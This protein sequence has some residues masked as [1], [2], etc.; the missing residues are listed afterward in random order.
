MQVFCETVNNQSEMMFKEA[1]RL[2]RILLDGVV[3]RLECSGRQADW[4]L[5]HQNFIGPTHNDYSQMQL[6]FSGAHGVSFQR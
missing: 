6:G 2:T 4:M 1:S 5:A 3:L